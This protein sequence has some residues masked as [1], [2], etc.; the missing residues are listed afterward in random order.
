MLLIISKRY[1]KMDRF[2]RRSS[3]LY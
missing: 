3:F 2:S 1:Q